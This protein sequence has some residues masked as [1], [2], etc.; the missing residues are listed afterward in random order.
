[1]GHS[2][3][4]RPPALADGL[5]T[6]HHYM[7]GHVFKREYPVPLPGVPGGGLIASIEDMTHYAIAHLDDGRY[8]SASI[9]SAQGVAELHAPAISSGGQQYYAM[10]LVVDS[11][12]GEPVL[13][14][15]GD[16][17]NFHSAL[18]LMPDRDLGFILLANASGFEQ[19]GQVDGIAVG[20]FNM[21][22]GNAP[23]PA[24]APINVRF[25]YWAVLLT[26]LLMII[27]IAYSLRRWLHKGVGYI[28]LMA[29]LYGGVALLWLIVVPHLTE[30]TFSTIRFVHPELAYAVLAS[31]VLGIGWSAIYTVMN[32]MARKSK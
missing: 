5:T 29:L 27:G 25:L 8:G 28:L 11:A 21:L 9:L 14:H 24:S 18:I 26:P 1:M 23:A 3:V 7:F 19:M 16:I 32:L 10:G 6:G 31:A 30:S 20:V 15:T 2:Y 13:L 22:N 4:S 17:G 12:D